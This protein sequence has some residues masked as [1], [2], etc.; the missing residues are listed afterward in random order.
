VPGE[1]SAQLSS[2]QAVRAEIMKPLAA[3][4]VALAAT[5]SLSVLSVDDAGAKTRRAAEK[6]APR[7]AET[8]DR[9]ARYRVYALR[10]AVIAC[11]ERRGTRVRLGANPGDERNDIPLVQEVELRGS[12]VAF[13]LRSLAPS[14][15][16]PFAPDD[17][18]L[19]S[20][21]K[22]SR[23]AI[24]PTGCP[25]GDGR[26]RVASFAHDARGRL[27]WACVVDSFGEERVEVRRFDRTGN[28]LLEVSNVRSLPEGRLSEVPINAQSV[29]LSRSDEGDAIAF[30]LRGDAPRAATL[31]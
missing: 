12:F 13:V 10:R 1:G 3:A 6:C 5:V 14:S 31:K 16:G 21:T 2:L 9:N 27:V 18:A 25:S 4:A 17:M 29:A 15:Q 8:L 26:G 7:G 30:W 19:V 20:L 23:V 24:G 28:A 11:D 22:R